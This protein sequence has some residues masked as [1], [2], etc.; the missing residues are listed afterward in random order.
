M[1]IMDDA[2]RECSFS[3]ANMKQK[4]N[5]NVKERFN[6]QRDTIRHFHSASGLNQ[7]LYALAREY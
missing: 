7:N 5:K 1:G 2:C 3:N 6:Q 4:D